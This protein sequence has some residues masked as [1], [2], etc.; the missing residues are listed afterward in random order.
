MNVAKEIQH[1]RDLMPAS[2]RMS[3]KLIA[4]GDRERAI[5]APFPYPWQRSRKVY[6]N[7]QYW[8]QLSRS[9]RDL[10]LLRT[11]S[12][13]TGVQWFTLD[14][15]RG[16]AVAGTL[17]TVAETLQG[18]PLGILAAGG[19][20][21]FAARQVWQNNKNSSRSEEHTSELQS[22]DHLVCRL[23]LEKK[24][25]QNKQKSKEIQ[26]KSYILSL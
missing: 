22:P 8:S 19:L 5:E 7:L 4:K 20:T 18:D 23:L 13:V 15:Y 17:A 10:L 3:V 25:K 14:L 12:W 24:K 1:L 16:A 21:A 2:G 9:E 26:N 11:V 6:L